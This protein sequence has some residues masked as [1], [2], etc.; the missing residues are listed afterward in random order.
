MAGAGISEQ[1]LQRYKEKFEADSKNKLAQN[2]VCKYDLL[3]VCVDRSVLHDTHQAFTHRVPE[4]K[5]MTNQRSSGRCWIFSCLNTMRIPYMKT[6]NLEDFE[7][8]QTHLFFWDKVE[9]VNFFLNSLVDVFRKGEAVDGRLVSFLLMDPINDGGQW[10]ML[11]NLI[12]KYGVMPKKCFPDSHSAGA[13]RRMCTILKCKIREYAFQLKKLVDSKTSDED[14]QKA[15]AD[16][17]EE[18]YR[19]CA[20]CLGVPPTTFTWEYHDKTKQFHK[21]GPITPKQF[22]DEH[23]KPVFNVDDKICLVNDPRPSN[24]YNK[25]YTVEFLGNMVGGRQT[26]YNNQPISVLKKLAAESI[27]SGEAVWFGCDVGKHNSGK[28]GIM[29]LTIV[30]YDLVFGFS[31]LGLDKANRLIYGESLMT[32]AMV[33]TGVSVDEAEQVEAAEGS[34]MKTTKWRV[35]NSW[36]EDRGEKGYFMMTDDWFSEFVYEVVIDKKYVPQEVQDVMKQAPVVLPAWDPMG[37]LAMS[38]L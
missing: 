24:T 21:L 35:E 8:S 15:L 19:I 34:D 10:D 4:V 9:R 14:I 27:K 17:M 25:V 29:D 3:E 36:G 33:L 38:K 16:M 23:V 28:T 7:F 5:P 6:I 18:I 37:A 30:N 1:Q 31:T 26:L 22:Y 32:H 11:V 13:T 20:I 2:V 12:N